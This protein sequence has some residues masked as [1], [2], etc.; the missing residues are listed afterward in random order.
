MEEESKKYLCR[1]R[2]MRATK[3]F[4]LKHCTASSCGSRGTGIPG[5][6]ARSIARLHEVIW[7]VY[8]WL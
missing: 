5:K 1:A 8:A 3:I 6:F 4:A 7:R 2:V